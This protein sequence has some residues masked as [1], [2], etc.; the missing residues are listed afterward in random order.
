[1]A[2][3]ALPTTVDVGTIAPRENHSL[4]FSSS[5]ALTTEQVKDLVNDHDL[6]GNAA[7]AAAKQACCGSCGGT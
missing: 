7:S 6:T 4:I 1:M 3:S 2:Q 5:R